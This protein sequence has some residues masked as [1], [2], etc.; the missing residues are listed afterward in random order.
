MDTYSSYCSALLSNK[1]TALLKDDRS[2]KGVE[3]NKKVEDEK[4]LEKVISKAWSQYKSKKNPEVLQK[5]IVKGYMDV[6][7][8]DL[9]KDP[10]YAPTLLQ[11]IHD[12]EMQNSKPSI[13]PSNFSQDPHRSASSKDIGQR[14]PPLSIGELPMLDEPLA[15]PPQRQGII[16]SGGSLDDINYGTSKPSF[17]QNLS[18]SPPVPLPN[19]NPKQTEPKYTSMMTSVDSLGRLD[20][21]LT[22]SNQKYSGN[23]A[24]DSWG[25]TPS[26]DEAPRFG[27]PSNSKTIE[28][29]LT[30]PINPILNNQNPPSNYTKSEFLKPEPYNS[31]PKKQP[32]IP[33]TKQEG[34]EYKP[35]LTY[36]QMIKQAPSES[37]LF[38]TPGMYESERQKLREN[39]VKQRQQEFEN[40]LQMIRTQ[41]DNEYNRPLHPMDLQGNPSRVW[42]NQLVA[43]TYHSLNEDYLKNLQEKVFQSNSEF[44]KEQLDYQ[45]LNNSINSYHKASTYFEKDISQQSKKA[46]ELTAR[47]ETLSMEISGLGHQKEDLLQKIE[48][49]RAE[50]LELKRQANATS[51]VSQVRKRELLDEVDAMRRLSVYKTSEL[52]RI[53]SKYDELERDFHN[54]ALARTKTME[55]PMKVLD[56]SLTAS[57]LKDWAPWRERFEDTS[58]TKS[59]K[60]HADMG[61][62]LTQ[63][64]SASFLADLN[65]SVDNILSRNSEYSSRQYRNL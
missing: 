37:T 34:W 56:K 38:N 27:P 61:I 9:T 65:R 63:G 17:G 30:P 6:M 32:V 58:G 13:Q 39:I 14:P 54:H 5:W 46:S 40:Q 53:K 62:T 16:H 48:R 41:G 47:A 35:D 7:N 23:N 31:I 8:K 57:A 59:R 29:P 21:P 2:A 3:L 1:N 33:E 10:E 11:N 25:N 42:S 20:P 52:S 49:K 43:N 4:Q 36:S 15:N 22:P 12:S 26:F 51:D 45:M 28:R 24:K 64:E 19:S 50:L 55:S 44:R 18:T 60:A